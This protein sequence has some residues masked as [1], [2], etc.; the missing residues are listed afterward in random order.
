MPQ[1]ITASNDEIIISTVKS[2]EVC[3]QFIHY[4]PPN[5]TVLEK[6]LSFLHI[7]PTQQNKNV[8]R[9]ALSLAGLALAAAGIAITVATAGIAAVVSGIVMLVVGA[10]FC[11]VFAPKK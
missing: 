1:A 10:I 8:A 3:P 5:L 7:Q 6:V 4:Q 2:E 11:V 9:C